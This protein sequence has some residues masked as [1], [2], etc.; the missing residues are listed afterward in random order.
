[1]LFKNQSQIVK[2]GRTSELKKIRQDILD[3][4][5][6]AYNAV[7]SYNSVK[8]HI[9][10]NQIIFENN[11]VDIKSF[12]NIYL[13]GFGKASVGMAQAVC[14]SID[15][16]EG[17]VLINNANKSVKNK[18]VKT[19][20]GSHPIPSKKNVDYTDKILELINKCRK[21]DLLIV[22]ISG[23]GSALLCKPRVNL[24]DLQKTTDL[25]LKSGANI[26]EI[27]TIRKHL[28]FVKGGHF[29]AYS[30]CKIISLIISDIIG[31]PIQFIASGPTHPDST[32]YKDAKNIFEKYGLWI[33][34]PNSVKKIIR[35]GIEGKIP[36]TPKKNDPIFKNV[37]NFIVANNEIACRAAKAK[38]E[39]LG[40]KA[41][42]LTTSLDGEAKEMGKYLAERAVDY[43]TDAKK[44]V[45]ISG[46]E[47]TVKVKGNGKGGR[48]QEIVLG[49]VKEL[50]SKNVIFSSFATDGIDGNSNAAGAI[51]DSYTYIRAQKKNLNPIKFLNDNN[52]NKFFNKLGDI[53]ITGLTDTN[54]MDIQI[55]VKKG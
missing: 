32:T 15:I 20:V 24:T 29:A 54:V 18:F 16:K 52:S 5:T 35:D 30:K 1:M 34:L 49:S 3:I 44:I 39:E 14:D 26:K 33:K 47:T 11:I 46:G 25:L 10:N 36:E 13:V 23:G 6:S 53:L 51:A 22:L 43:L 2:H 17:I 19:Y 27:N 7:D 45:F 28:S 9:V 4:L 8:N 41:M 42:L 21:N 50:S 48:N 31:D 12:D 37:S 38:S 55:L 40:Y